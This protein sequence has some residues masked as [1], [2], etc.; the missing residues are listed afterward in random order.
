MQRASYHSPYLPSLLILLALLSKH[1]QKANTLVC[2]TIVLYLDHSKSPLPTLLASPYPLGKLFSA[3]QPK[4]CLD[5]VQS[6]HVILLPPNPALAPISEQKLK[7]LEYPTTVPIALSS[8]TYLLTA[9]P[10]Q[11]H[12]P[13]PEMSFPQI[14]VAVTSSLLSVL[15]TSV[16]PLTTLFKIT[17]LHHP[18]P[19]AL[20]CFPFFHCP[21]HSLPIL[22]NTV[23]LD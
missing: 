14:S 23:S 5:V 22:L 2:T 3:Q 9:P 10:T 15:V 7:F 19:T 12:V 1:T 16:R 11:W 6:N 17:I 8:Q 18:L 20:P 4:R 13:L 21:F